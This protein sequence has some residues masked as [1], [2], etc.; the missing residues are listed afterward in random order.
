MPIEAC[1]FHPLWLAVA[2]RETVTC[3]PECLLT[4]L[5]LGLGPPWTICSGWIQGLGPDA[6][7]LSGER[8][9][10]SQDSS[11]WASFLTL[12]VTYC[13]I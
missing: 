11:P 2:P 12:L 5:D 7:P 10:Q 8:G 13:E 3:I 1:S 4:T 6:L 9:M